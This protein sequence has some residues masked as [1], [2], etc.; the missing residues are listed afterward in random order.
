MVSKLS[1]EALLFD[2]DGV[3]VDSLDS[4]WKSLNNALK[5]EERQE[6]T[7]KTF[8]E[9]YWGDTL[10]QNLEKLGIRK[11]NRQ[12]CNVFYQ[13]YIDEVTVFDR[14]KKNT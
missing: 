9:K 10:Q 12:F 5:K 1:P 3:L 13:K 2:M 6:I 8:I 11:E 4:W 14:T 7:K